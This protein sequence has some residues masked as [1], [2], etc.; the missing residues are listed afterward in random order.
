MK[1]IQRTALAW[2]PALVIVWGASPSAKAAVRYVPSV[3]YPTIQ[4][5]VTAA[6]PGDTIQLGLGEFRENVTIP[7]A[8]TGLSIFG[9]CGNPAGVVVDGTIGATNGIVFTVNA[10]R[11]SFFCLTIRHGSQGIYNQANDLTVNQVRFLHNGNEALYT[12]GSGY[13]V[14]YSTIIGSRAHAIYASGDDGQIRNNTIKGVDSDCVFID[15]GERTII[16]AN[17]ISLCDGGGVVAKGVAQTFTNNVL[18][19]TDGGAISLSDA[20]DSIIA[21]NKITNTLDSGIYLAGERGQIKSNQIEAAHREGIYVLGNDV[22]VKGNS[23]KIAGVGSGPHACYSIDGNRPTV[24]GNTASI[25]GY[26]GIETRGTDPIVKNNRVERLNNGGIG[27]DVFCEQGSSSGRVEMNTATASNGYNG[28]WVYCPAV[29]GFVVA[30]NTSTYNAGYGFEL[31]LDDSSIVENAG[32]FNGGFRENG[33]YV[34][35]N[36]NVLTLNVADD[37]IE[38]GYY[39]CG[40]ANTLKYN[41]ARRNLDDGLV[42]DCGFNNTVE[43]ST[44]QYNQGEGIV[45]RTA[46]NTLLTNYSYNNRRTRGGTGGDCTSDFGGALTLTGNT[47]SDGSN[48]LVPSDVEN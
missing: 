3:A 28:F 47:C 7:A 42:L 48:F 1:A 24:D 34:E 31:F 26:S 14:L 46:P 38:D 4:S 36:R 9:S 40:E 6:T 19:A 25:C 33:F 2:L 32:N 21:F 12:S 18:D 16:D 29:P 22:E 43:L 27:I 23:V 5:A 13:K 17:A 39:I 20:N 10:V 30:K 44:I 41:Q 15:F 45:V 8:K 11:T 35:G 37:N